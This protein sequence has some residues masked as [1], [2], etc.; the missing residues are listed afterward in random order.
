MSS[1]ATTSANS[2]GPIIPASASHLMGEAC[3]TMD[4]VLPSFNRDNVDM[5]YYLL[6]GISAFFRMKD[7]PFSSVL[8]QRIAD[9]LSPDQVTRVLPWL[10]R[11]PGFREPSLLPLPCQA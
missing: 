3:P 4:P 7:E 5:V 11:L 1:S 10:G 2:K 9:L 6:A 8:R